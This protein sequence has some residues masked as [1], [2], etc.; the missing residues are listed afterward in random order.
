MMVKGGAK[1][2]AAIRLTVG[3]PV[4][5][6]KQLREEAERLGVSLGW[7]VR[8]AVSVYLGRPPRILPAS[9]DAHKQR[10]RCE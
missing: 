4:D 6:Y 1:K 2:S 9:M 5:D 8:E 3:F 7:V 10:R